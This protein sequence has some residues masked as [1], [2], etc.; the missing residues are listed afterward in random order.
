MYVVATFWG[1]ALLVPTIQAANTVTITADTQY[2]SQRDCVKQCLGSGE[3]TGDFLPALGC[4]SPYLNTC[5]CRSSNANLASSFLSTCIATQCKETVATSPAPALSRALSL[6]NTYCAS[7]GFP[8]PT[9]ASLVRHSAYL[10]QPSCVQLCLWHPNQVTDD[11]MPNMGCGEPWV[12]GCLCSTGLA[13]KASSFLSACVASRCGKPTTGPDVGAAVGAFDGYCG[14]VR[15]EEGTATGM[16]AEAESITGTTATS[17]GQGSTVVA[18]ETGIASS[19]VNAGLSGGTIAG[20]VIGACAGIVLVLV[21][22]FVL[23]RRA[24]RTKTTNDAPSS[25]PDEM[26]TYGS[27]EQQTHSYY[28]PV[29]NSLMELPDISTSPLEMPSTPAKRASA[30]ELQ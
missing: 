13:T 7:A 21:V 1:V 25:E 28:P 29:P 22:G 17:P 14:N 5:F 19:G 20:I 30:V 18:T 9:V 3:A 23:F 24:R 16:D 11:L 4:T 26:K 8:I 15:R 6:Y 12:N 2:N 10:D 27:S